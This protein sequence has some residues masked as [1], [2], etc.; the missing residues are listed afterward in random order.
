MP[1]ADGSLQVRRGDRTTTVHASSRAAGRQ[2]IDAIFEDSAGTIWVG[3]TAGLWRV[4]DRRVEQLGE[5][6]GLPAERVMAIT[7]SLDGDLWLAVDRGPRLPG[8]RAALIRLNPSDF[9]RATAGDSPFAGYRI[10]DAMN[11]LAGFP[12]GVTA[13]RSHDG[14]LWFA[15][16]GVLTVV[17]PTRVSAE[18]HPAPAR[19]A[20]VTVDDR[21]V[22]VGDAG[23][24]APGTRKVQIDYT[25]LRLTAPR[26]VRFRYRLDGFDADWVNA[27]VRRQAYTRTS[28]RGITCSA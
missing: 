22:A 7:Q 23:V 1:A 5:R 8:R 20:G 12:L 17:D 11:G 18:R 6:E 19:I 16:G 4:R 25:A 13:A 3:G 27:G 28:R 2:T 14:S 21:P 24:L 9:E 10:Y 15:F 26:Q